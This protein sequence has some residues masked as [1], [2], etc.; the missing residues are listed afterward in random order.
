MRVSD[1][2]Q[3]IEDISPS[4]LAHMCHC[5]L[6][7]YKT[8]PYCQDLGFPKDKRFEKSMVLG[9][10]LHDIGKLKVPAKILN[11]TSRLTPDEFK[12]MQSHTE[13]GAEVLA[14]S[15]VTCD[16]EYDWKLIYQLA[17]FHHVCKTRRGYPSEMP[18][19]TNLNAVYL[20]HCID[21]YEAL[22]GVRPY[23]A[24]LTPA[25]AIEMVRTDVPSDVCTAFSQGVLS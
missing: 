16:T 5:G 2:L 3:Q 20:M 4:T 1:L 23:R 6:L 13:K 18:N 8:L 9:A 24:A 19:D 11:G 22:T 21:V 17:R 14:S 15:G 25:M 12:L 7:M 10:I